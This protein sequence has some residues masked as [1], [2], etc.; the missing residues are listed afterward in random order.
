MNLLKK[1]KVVFI[2]SVMMVLVV[3]VVNVYQYI[4][5]SPKDVVEITPEYVGDATEFNFLVTDNLSYWTGKVV[6]ITG[7]V[8]ELTEYG[9]VMNGTIFCQFENGDDLQSIVENQQINIKG[10]LVGFDEILMEIK[11]NQCI[12]P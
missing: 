1:N 12:L 11:L 6:Q 4:S 9:I 10:K 3:G 5:M 2:A 7:K 8:T